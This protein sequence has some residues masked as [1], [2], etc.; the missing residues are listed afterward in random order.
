MGFQNMIKDKKGFEF[1]STF[2]ALVAVG[3][4]IM[5]IG[6]TIGSWGA[7]YNSG[8]TYDLGDYNENDQ[9]SSYVGGYAGNVTPN[10]P[11][12][13]G[14]NVET[15]TYKGVYGIITN[16]FKPF[17]LFLG[18]GG[19]LDKISERIGLPDYLKEGIIIMALAAMVFSIIA[20]IFRQL[21]ESV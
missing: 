9:L 18:E 3:I 15:S 5:A 19:V 4:I 20:I 11:N 12:N 2:F 13:L 1:K 10:S 8:I 7:H 6:T 17:N 14:D 21:R 16:I